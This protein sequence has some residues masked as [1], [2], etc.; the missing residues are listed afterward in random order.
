MITFYLSFPNGINIIF[1]N[2]PL[3]YN[4]MYRNLIMLFLILNRNTTESAKGI[5]I[6]FALLKK[7]VT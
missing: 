3:T 6:F 7:C 4:F 1:L 2:D 5:A